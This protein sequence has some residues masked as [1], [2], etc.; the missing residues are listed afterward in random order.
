M[1]KILSTLVI[2]MTLSLNSAYVGAHSKGDVSK[3]QYI[4][5]AV[6]EGKDAAEAEK[7]FDSL[8]AN[9]DGVLSST[10]QK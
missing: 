9:K 1:F 6:S 4:E 2:M 5:K 10:E 3:E 7:T 8:D